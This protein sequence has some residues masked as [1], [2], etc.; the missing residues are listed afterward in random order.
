MVGPVSANPQALAAYAA[1][2]ALVRNRERNEENGTQEEAASSRTTSRG[3][4][5]S[6]S[7]EAQRLARQNGEAENGQTIAEQTGY[8]QA[9]ERK[10]LE[11]PEETQAAVA[12]SVAEAIRAYSANVT[13]NLNTPKPTAN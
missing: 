2:P 10:R 13:N 3:E 4:Q 5:V 7:Q 6:L 1:Q 9:V 12:K 11:R 8:P